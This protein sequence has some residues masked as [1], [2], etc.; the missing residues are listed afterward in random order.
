MLI[1]KCCVYDASVLKLNASPTFEERLNWPQKYAHLKAKP[2]L[3]CTTPNR[4]SSIVIII[5]SG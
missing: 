1:N 5:Q 2:D 3:Q 4:F